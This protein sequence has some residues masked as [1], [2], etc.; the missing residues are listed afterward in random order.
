ML[1]VWQS[2]VLAVD[3]TPQDFDIVS[4]VNFKAAYFLTQQVAKKLIDTGKTGSLIH[5]SS[6]MAHVGGVERAV[7][8]ATKHAIEGM[9]KSNGD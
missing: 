2:I 7:Y 9:V 1:Q 5:I 8:S 3:T 6:Q 4:Q